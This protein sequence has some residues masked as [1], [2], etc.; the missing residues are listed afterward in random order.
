[1]SEAKIAARE[2]MVMTLD[3]GEYWWCACGL[4]ANQPFCDGSHKTTDIRP[5]QFTL[6]ARKEV[7]LCMCKRTGTPPFCDGSHKAL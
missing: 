1:M 7:A 5:V 6:E 4:S 2:P 3:A